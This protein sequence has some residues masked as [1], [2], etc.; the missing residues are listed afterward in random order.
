MLMRNVELER[1]NRRCHPRLGKLIVGLSVGEVAEPALPADTPSDR[2]C[3]Q[4]RR[5]GRPSQGGGIIVKAPTPDS[6]KSCPEALGIGKRQLLTRPHPLIDGRLAYRVFREGRLPEVT[7]CIASR[8]GNSIFGISDRMLTSGDI[9][10]EPTEGSKIV[11]LT[12]SMFM[13][14]AG[15]AGLSA[16]I[17][18]PMVLEI[19]NRVQLAPQN[20]WTAREVADLYIKYYNEIRQRRA[21]DAI[22]RPLYMDRS[23]FAANQSSMDSRLVNDISRELLNFRMPNVSAIT[24]EIDPT[25]AHIYLVDTGE[26]NALEATCMD[27]VG[28]V[29]IGSGGRH[30][31]SQFMFARHAWNAPVADTLFL[32]Y[33]AKRK[34]E[35]APGV[36]QGTDMVVVGPGVGT[37]ALVQPEIVDKLETEY[38]RVIRAEKRGFARAKVEV[39][40]Y[41]QELQ[42][43]AAPGQQPPPPPASDGG[44]TPSNGPKT[45]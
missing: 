4:G 25:G 13:M 2:I 20:W 41:V 34:A 43:Q 33:Y 26:T 19:I 24:A 14:T 27:S 1:I 40:K 23:S 3:P 31:S 7:V 39:N 28:F 36:G 17:G 11:G 22:L 35:V 37:L 9:Q 6:S 8:A 42:G 16:Q 10:F 30:A 29:A 12:N 45:G 38:N 15:D 5:E 32:S 21:E 18:S 44:T